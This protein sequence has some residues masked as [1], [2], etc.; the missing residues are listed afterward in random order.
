VLELI[1]LGTGGVMPSETR[2]LPSV[3]LRRGAELFMFDCGECSQ[4]QMFMAKLGFNRRMKIFITHIHGDHI[5]G[6]P[7]LLHSM[8]FLGRNRMLEIF[9]PEGIVEFIEAICKTVKFN[10]AFPLVVHQ[11]DSGRL[12]EEEDYTVD[13]AWME[14]GFPCLGFA[15]TEKDKPGRFNPAKARALGVPEGPLWKKLQR[16]ETV[17]LNGVEVT[18]AQVLGPSRKGAKIVYITDTKPCK[19]AIELAKNASILM[20]DCTFDSMKAD[21]AMKYG[22]STSVDAATIAKEANVEKLVLLHV[23]TIYR[24]ATPLLNEAKEIFPDTIMA[25][26]MM[27]LTVTP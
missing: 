15:L 14:H 21:R 6:L 3:V 11:A 27:R 26:D 20:Y 2:G 17:T 12:I 18:P 24:D 19:N 22:H 5:F 1:F 4:R 13:A 23:S 7:G 25:F 9:G 8:S 10:P 16:G